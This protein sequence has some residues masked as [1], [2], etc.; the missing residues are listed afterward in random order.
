MHS[1]PIPEPFSLAEG[2]AQITPRPS[3]PV[4]HYRVVSPADAPRE[5]SF[6]PREPGGGTTQ[7]AS[8]LDMLN[9]DVY[10]VENCQVTDIL[11]SE[12]RTVPN[13]IMQLYVLGSSVS[14]QQHVGKGGSSEVPSNSQGT[15]EPFGFLRLATFPNQPPAFQLILLPYGYPRLCTIIEELRAKT[16]APPMLRQDLEN[17]VRAVPS[18]YVKPLRVAFKNA[19]PPLPFDRQDPPVPVSI[20][21]TL[22]RYRH[23]VEEAKEAN[24]RARLMPGQPSSQVPHA[25]FLLNCLLAWCLSALRSRCEVGSTPLA[26]EKRR[27]RCLAAVWC[28]KICGAR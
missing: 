1:W 23:V 10:D 7:Q 18:Y 3:L 22:S 11:R 20:L 14:S 26:L 24:K 28:G 6:V 9:P 27:C 25:I 15:E 12:C 4:I 5:T 19:R 13:S 2:S 21:G 8:T 16:P 17:Y